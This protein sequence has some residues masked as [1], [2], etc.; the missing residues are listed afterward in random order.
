[1]PGSTRWAPGAYGGP[2]TVR[3]NRRSSVYAAEEQWA[4]QLARGGDV[5]FFGTTMRIPLERRFADIA[6][7]Q[8]YVDAVM[9]LP[10]V[11]TLWPAIP[12]VR[13]RERAGAA[14]AHYS[15]GVIA[16]PLS[17]LGAQRWAA[18]ESVVL[19]EL[20]HHVVAHGHPHVA[21]HGPQ[22]CTEFVALVEVVLGPEAALLLR[23]ALDEAGLT[24]VGGVG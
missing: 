3:D 9:G 17:G 7:V 6:S 19:H 2:V 10:M 20:T 18:R 1:V 15:E 24:R 11:G 4:R 13:V 14:R 22:F 8:R 23:A 21:A 12:P 5:D 16:L